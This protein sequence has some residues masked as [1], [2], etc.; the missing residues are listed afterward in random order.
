MTITTI[1]SGL[2]RVTMCTC[3][4][5]TGWLAGRFGIK[6][7]FFVSVAGFTLASA[8]CGA[9]TSLAPRLAFC[10]SASSS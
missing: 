3:L 8:L 4:L 1:D 10:A 7:V 6:Y 9:A 2:R 5:L